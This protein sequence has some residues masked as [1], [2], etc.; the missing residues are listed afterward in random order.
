MNLDA[1]LKSGR[2]TV[3]TTTHCIGEYMLQI[4]IFDKKGMLA[5]SSTV[6]ISN[7]P[8]DLKAS[9]TDAQIQAC[10]ELHFGLKMRLI[11]TGG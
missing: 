10:E 4:P 9:F 5:G 7:I 11:R 1:Q 8:I 2:F 6:T 3:S